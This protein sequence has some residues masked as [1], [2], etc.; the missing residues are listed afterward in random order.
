MFK[1]YIREFLK[2]KIEASGWDPE[3]CHP[4]FSPEKLPNPEDPTLSEEQRVKIKELI[5]KRQEFIDE[6][7]EIYGIVIDPNNMK[8]NLGLRY[9]AK[10]F[11]TYAI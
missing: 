4:D 10:V 11:L 3:L 9:I 5:K 6:T 2:I 8:K 7:F 1:N